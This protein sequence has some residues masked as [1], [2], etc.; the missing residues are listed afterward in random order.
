MRAVNEFRTLLCTHRIHFT[1]QGP[2]WRDA[3]CCGSSL[4]ISNEK[5]STDLTRAKLVEADP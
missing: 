4:K 5:I 2:Y 3:R 1:L